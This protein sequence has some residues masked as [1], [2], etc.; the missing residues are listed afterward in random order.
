MSNQ[1]RMSKSGV[2]YS[3]VGLAASAAVALTAFLYRGREP[4]EPLLTADF[5]RGREVVCREALGEGTYRL[6]IVGDQYVVA[7][8]GRHFRTD[9]GRELA[10]GLPGRAS[11]NAEDVDKDGDL[12]LVIAVGS[13]YDVLSNKGNGEFSLA[14]ASAVAK[15]R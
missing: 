7:E 1:V 4:I 5:G 13:Q 15:R 3:A 11:V 12:D 10:R 8:N 14:P 6:F 2:I 9:K